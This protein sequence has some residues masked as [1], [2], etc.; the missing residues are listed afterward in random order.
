MCPDRG[1]DPVRA[2]ERVAPLLV[3]VGEAHD[4]A[5]TVLNEAD[6]FCSQPHCP[7]RE[8]G[9]QRPLQIRPVDGE[10]RLPEPYPQFV[11]R[12]LEDLLATP[13]ADLTADLGHTRCADRVEDAKSLQRLYRVGPQGDARPDLPHLARP[14]EHHGLHADLPQGDRRREPAYPCADDKRLRHDA[15]PSLVSNGQTSLKQVSPVHSSSR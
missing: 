3:S 15:P 9:Q 13:R 10:V 7:F 11:R 5:R 14:F 8:G 6:T 2:D 1:V 12:D 4:H